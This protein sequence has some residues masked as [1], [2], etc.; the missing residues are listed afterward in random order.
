MPPGSQTHNSGVVAVASRHQSGSVPG[1]NETPKPTT[2]RLEPDI[3]RRVDIYA[4][5][6]RR[7]L[8]M[9]V[10]HLLG[11]ALDH[12]ASSRPGDVHHR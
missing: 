1:V 12:H 6:T 4:H 2:L 10:N 8:N 5:E 3:R 9:A 7:T 11:E